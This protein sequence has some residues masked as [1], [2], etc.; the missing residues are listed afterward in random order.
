MGD[1]EGRALAGM[2]SHTD[3]RAVVSEDVEDDLMSAILHTRKD[4]SDHRVDTLI[5]T[6][7]H[8][9]IGIVAGVV[10]ALDVQDAPAVRR[11]FDNLCE[12]VGL[13]L[14]V[15]KEVSRCSGTH[16]HVNNQRF[17]HG[18]TKPIPTVKATPVT[19][20]VGAITNGR[21]LGYNVLKGGTSTIP[22]GPRRST[23]FATL[24]P[25]TRR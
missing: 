4:E 17:K 21:R 13:F 1:E 18:Q 7:T 25:S 20:P 8:V 9:D 2:V 6:P 14:E 19:T 16:I 11:E 3:R 12:K 23:M 22:P 10:A 24:S 15:C 5:H